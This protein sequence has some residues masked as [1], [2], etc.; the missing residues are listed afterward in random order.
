MLQRLLKHLCHAWPNTLIVVRGDSHV[1]SPEVMQGIEAQANLSDVT[2][3]TSNAIVQK[4]AHAVVAQAKRAYGRD[5]GTGPR[6]HSTR[7]QAGTWSCTSRVGITV[8]VTDQGVNTR[9]VVTDLEQA[10]AHVLSRHIDGARGQAE[11][12]IKDHKRSLKA[13]RTA[14]HRFAAN[15]FRLLLH[16]AAS[17]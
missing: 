8:E 1:A 9:C 13:D 3:L 2:G 11:H 16:A 6:F 5:G 15:P 12:A 7:Y 4:R 14:W 17:V 10:R